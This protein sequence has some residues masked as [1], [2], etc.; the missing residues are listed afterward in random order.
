MT[1]PSGIDVSILI[2]SYNTRALTL[3]AL[4]SAVRETVQSSFETIIVDNAS[5]DGSAT[6]L[7]QHPSKPHVIA[8]HEN[9]GFGR[10]NNLA[11]KHARGRYI[12]LLNP[13]TV[14][15]DGAIDALVDF[16]DAYPDAM[17]WGGRTVFADGSLYP[18]SCWGRMTLWNQFCRV[19]GLTGVFSQI[20]FFNG[21]GYGGWK[22]DT[23]RQIDIVS[24]CF[25][26]IE[27]NAWQ[28]LGG[29][30]PH[31]FM[32]G[33]DADLCLRAQRMGAK[34]MV[35]PAATIVH[36]GGASETVRTAKMVR[37]LSAKAS[38]ISRHWHPLLSPVGQGLLALWP[39]SRAVALTCASAVTRSKGHR[40]A[41][42]TW[43]EIWAQ[44]AQWRS[45]Y[46]VHDLSDGVSPTATAAALNTVA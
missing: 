3:E 14:V 45:G 27:R 15:L 23:V 12:L 24:G 39:L 5:H 28:A 21:E 46:P 7:A 8:L 31:F 34:P 40:D 43:A 30:D 36:L 16:A 6:A 18:T 33:E 1:E 32:Y 10:A 4:S 38:L 22:H 42:K 26:L 13:D 44:R 29:F 20:E 35:T 37:L 9:I 19:T 2:V 11:A 41:A 17:I 25:L